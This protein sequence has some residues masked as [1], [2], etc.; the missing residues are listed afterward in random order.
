[1]KD[2]KTVNDIERIKKINRI[3]WIN[4]FIRDILLAVVI[5]VVNYRTHFI[6]WWVGFVTGMLVVWVTWQ[7]SDFIRYKKIESTV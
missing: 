1:M 5:V 4:I 6:S 7:L 3:N 2:I